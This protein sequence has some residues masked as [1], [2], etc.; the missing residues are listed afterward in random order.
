MD[1]RDFLRWIAVSAGPAFLPAR[2][3]AGAAYERLLILVELKGG[4]DGLNTLVPFA[5][6]AY[7]RLRPRLALRREEAIQLD[8]RNGLHPALRPLLPLW[9]A[10][11]LAAIQGL[12]YPSPNLS[13]FR[14]IEI[15]DTASKSAEYLQAGWLARAFAAHPPPA[16]FAA[17]G[18]LVG[19]GELGPLAGGARAIALN[20][21]AEFLRQARLAQPA[22]RA[23]NA[24]LSHIRKVESDIALAGARLANAQA[25]LRTEFP[26]GEFGNAVRTACQ[27]LAG[28]A[29][30]AVLRLSLGGFD[31]H[32]NQPGTHASLLSQLAEGLAALK[33]ALQEL[34]RWERTLIL[35]YAEFGRRPQENQSNGTDHGTANVHFA[36]G[37]RVRGGLYGAPPALDRLDGNGN[38]PFAVD[39]RSLYATALARWWGIDPAP[40]LNGRFETLPILKA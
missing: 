25:S 38:L 5:D 22:M 39:F 21:P 2:A 19:S 34:D 3:W 16:A 24:A 10:G 15:W 35:T 11:E 31:T 17:E 20:N 27:V 6:P 37:G 23:G 33:S 26:R 30:T 29:E 8:E 4:N 7:H 12:G 14:S 18:V 1:R 40:V 9:Q 28:G 13:H 36:L 32:Q